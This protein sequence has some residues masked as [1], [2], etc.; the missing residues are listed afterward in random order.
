MMVMMFVFNLLFLFQISFVF[1]NQITHENSTGLQLV[2]NANNLNKSIVQ[3]GR[4]RA[5]V[6][7][8]LTLLMN[9]RDDGT[10]SFQIMQGTQIV[11]LDNGLCV[12]G[13]LFDPSTGRCRD[14]YCQEINYKFN[15]TTCIPDTNQNTSYAF[16]RMSD[17][18]L[19]LTM[20]I[21]PSSHYPANET[22][23]LLTTQINKTCTKDLKKMFHDALHGYLNIDYERVTKIDYR[24]SVHEDHSVN[25]STINSTIQSKNPGKDDS[26]SVVHPYD[27]SDEFIYNTLA[28][29]KSLAISFSFSITDRNE[30]SQD[31]L[32]G[33][34]VVTLLLIGSEFHA[35]LYLCR[36]YAIEI[37]GVSIISD[38]NKTRDEFCSDPDVMMPTK[39]G[40]I[41]RRLRADGEIDYVVDVP[42]LETTYESGDYTY[43][44]IIST[45]TQK[46]SR[47]L[48]LR[49][50]NTSPP[51]NATSTRRLVSVCNR[52]PRIVGRCPDSLVMRI[53][54]CEVVQYKNLS[55]RIRRT[56][57]LYTNREYRYDH[58]RPDLY[59]VVCKLDTHNGTA[60]GKA[61]GFVEKAPGILSTI[62]TFLSIFALAISLITFTLFSSLRNLPGCN[63][64]NLIIALMIGET[65]FLSQSLIIMTT[66]SVCLLFA[67]GIHFF[68]LASFF[69]MNV[70]AFDLWKT[71]H[72]G[73]SLYVYE[74]R[75]RLPFYAL[76]AWGMPM[77]IVLIGIIL[78]AKNA[79]LKPCYG[80]FFRGCYD[81]CFRTKNDTPLQGCWIESALMRFILFGC[82][83]AIILIINFVFYALTVRSI[84]KG[85]KKVRV[86]VER[87]FQ[88]KKQVV[89]G[90]H[91]VKIY[92]RMAVLAGFGWTIGFILFL[93]PDNQQG[94][95]RFLVATVKYLFILLNA[96]PGL[97]I[98]A[99]YVCN[100][101]VLSLYHQLLK[102]I[103]Q[104][105]RSNVKGMKES[106]LNLSRNCLS[107]TK[108]KL[109]TF[110]Q[111]KYRQKQEDKLIKALTVPTAVQTSNLITSTKLLS[112]P[113]VLPSSRN[114]TH[115]RLDSSTSLGRQSSETIESYL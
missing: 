19:S 76:Y 56:G 84:R 50:E 53:A 88:R 72:K 110:N 36:N 62:A 38:K 114:S 31:T 94:F 90:E 101:R 98:F 68:Y 35:V 1:A 52:Q 97:F 58:L 23:K 67:L 43:L 109:E 111:S 25:R 95:K 28:R 37:E 105:C 65:L 46:A 108:N 12:Y 30:T 83:V 102:D 48:A 79:R 69:W 22:S 64:I 17:I 29:N 57:R 18:D 47:D 78:D 33:L 75:E 66:P 54:L 34:H 10:T 59:V 51:P 26:A 39:N 5:G 27:S 80:R 49:A 14:I 115:E 41:R 81:V 55:M 16:K 42:E 85:L 13:Q 70:M 93:L 104:F 71:F 82:P 113:Q 86:Q 21:A 99:V 106:I 96:T 44:F 73:F 6:P 9:F 100:R 103:Y 24:V 11:Y 3:Q 7:Q 20:I 112:Q 107:K 2:S 4:N 77:I 74:I 91:D 92:M 89:P 32:T 63:T 87:K 40:Y 45:V 8:S 15:G 60:S 61:L